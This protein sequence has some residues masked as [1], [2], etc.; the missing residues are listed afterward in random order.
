MP[1]IILLS[2]SYLCFRYL[3]SYASKSEWPV[4]YMLHYK[5]NCA[6]HRVGPSKTLLKNNFNLKLFKVINLHVILILM[7]LLCVCWVWTRKLN[8][9][10]ILIPKNLEKHQ[11]KTDFMKNTKFTKNL[12][13][14]VYIK[15]GL[16]ML[17]FN[18]S[19]E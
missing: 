10:C 8:D 3:C 7:K 4:S 15:E 6:M 11:W 17:I 19:L 5:F 1:F 16:M 13:S 14:K 18:C 12:I 2:F 9:I